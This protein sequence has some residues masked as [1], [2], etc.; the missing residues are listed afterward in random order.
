MISDLRKRK[1]NDEIIH[2]TMLDTL[3]DPAE[4]QLGPSLSISTLTAEAVVLLFAGAEATSLTLIL[5]TFHILK[6]CNMLTKLQHEL[7]KVMIDKRTLPSLDILRGLPYLV[8]TRPLI[9]SFALLNCKPKLALLKKRYDFL[10]APQESCHGLHL[11][12]EQ[13]FVDNGFHQR[14]ELL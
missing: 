5:G 12:K 7:S 13:R 9:V 2:P 1:E 3:I 8:R 4:K 6:D 11:M 10:M 14:S